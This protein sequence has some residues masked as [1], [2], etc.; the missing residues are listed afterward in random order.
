MGMSDTLTDLASG[1]PDPD[2]LP[3]DLLGQVLMEMQPDGGSPLDPSLMA[4]AATEFDADGIPATHLTIAAGALDAI[5]RLLREHLRTGDAVALEDP[6]LPEIRELV[7]M[8]GFPATP[9]AIDGEG[10]QPDSVAAA[11]EGGCRAVIVTPRAQN[12][13]GASISAARAAE[14]RRL[15]R[16]HPQ[17]LVIE[18]DYA[19][20]IAGSPGGPLRTSDGAWAVVRSTSKFLGPDLRLALVAG[21]KTTIARVRHRQALGARW[22]SRLVQRLVLASWSDPSGARRLARAAEIY[23]VRREA[24]VAALADHGIAAPA[25]SGFNLW[26]RV[27]EE[28]SVVAALMTRGWAVAA[29]ERFRMRAAPAIRVTTSALDSADARRFAADLAA[30]TGRGRAAR[31]Y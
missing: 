8:S 12:P 9:V 2:L 16:K 14:L 13:T 7:V 28:S 17:V 11:L 19:A 15:L 27:R 1:A 25:R 3:R 18:N 31:T 5:E 4:F 6:V 26:V 30:V 21:E 10:P 22:V 24:L 23:T 29:G 20:P